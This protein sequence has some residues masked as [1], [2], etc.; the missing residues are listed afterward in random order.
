MSFCIAIP[1]SRTESHLTLM[2]VEGGSVYPNYI[3]VFS[4]VELVNHGDV[5][6]G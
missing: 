5:I 2:S 4:N 6:Y 1:T 3:N